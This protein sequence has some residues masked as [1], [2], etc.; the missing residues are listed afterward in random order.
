MKKKWQYASIT[1]LMALCSIASGWAQNFTIS[2]DCPEI[3]EFNQDDADMLICWSTDKEVAHLGDTIICMCDLYTQTPPTKLT[4]IGRCEFNDCMVLDDTTKHISVD[5][6]EYNGRSYKHIRLQAVKIV[7]L[8]AGIFNIGGN[9][10]EL[11]IVEHS[12]FDDYFHS[13]SSSRHCYNVKSESVSFRV[14]DFSEIHKGKTE[15]GEECFLLCDVSGSMKISDMEPDRKTCVKDFANAWLA[16]MPESGVITFA[17]GVEQ[18]YPAKVRWRSVDLVEEPK[19]DGT[20][21]GD[22][23]VTPIAQGANVK[24]IIVI[25]DGSNNTGH[26]SLET[27]FKIMQRY[28]VR[29]SYVY[30]NSGK[31]SVQLMLKG[32]LKK[33]T[34]ANTR[35]PEEELQ[36][37]K[38]MVE[39]SGGIFRV[40][41]NRSELMGYL[42]QLKHLVESP[43]GQNDSECVLDEKMLQKALKQI[44]L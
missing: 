37:I 35:V 2:L 19:K 38:A 16:E 12:I 14:E 29:V 32:A 3:V 22:A 30:L 28:N 21:I 31:D 6:V 24:D 26:L 33:I 18:Y 7:P 44:K 34:T 39:H 15:P 17:A 1:L 10:Y 8:R 20:A 4:P 5:K 11:L 42:N 9:E 41:A 25:T 43:Q 23:M 40:A 36:Q 13:P 27:A